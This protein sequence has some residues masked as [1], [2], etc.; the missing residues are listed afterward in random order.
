[1]NSKTG[2]K[3]GGVSGYFF[4]Q[5]FKSNPEK[6]FFTLKR[7]GTGYSLEG[8]VRLKVGLVPFSLLVNSTGNQVY[9]GDGKMK[10]TYG[11][12]TIDV[13]C[14]YPFKVELTKNR[15]QFFIR[16]FGPTLFP[17]TVLGG[18]PSV[19]SDWE[20]SPNALIAY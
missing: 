19:R 3:A 14:R 18:C 11:T 12:S 5:E 20:F 1:M 17:E 7:W 6:I 2:E 4:L 13:N 8:H 9:S 10:M 15:G 16:W